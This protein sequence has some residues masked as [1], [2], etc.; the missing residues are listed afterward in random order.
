MPEVSVA[1]LPT[2]RVPI[3]PHARDYDDSIAHDSI[4]DAIRKAVHER[5][6]RVA[7]D[8]GKEFWRLGDCIECR[9]DFV[10]ELVP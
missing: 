1:T 6:S 3:T 9:R 4:E 2:K 5:T 8:N 7:M 10:E